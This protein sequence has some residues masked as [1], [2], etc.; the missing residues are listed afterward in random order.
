M[1]L[2]GRRKHLIEK[3][4]GCNYHEQIAIASQLGIDTPKLETLLNLG[5]QIECVCQEMQ[6]ESH[7][8]ATL[9][10]VAMTQAM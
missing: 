6:P 8:P 2:F 5:R 1:L 4:A 7:F 3:E 10:L 9:R